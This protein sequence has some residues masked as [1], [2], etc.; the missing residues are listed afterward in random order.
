MDNRLQAFALQKKTSAA[1]RTLW[2]AVVTAALGAGG[3]I[4]TAV[5]SSQQSI[6]GTSINGQ[7]ATTA[8]GAVTAGVTLVGTALTLA[9]IGPAPADVLAAIDKADA[10]VIAD[11][12]AFAQNCPVVPVV[13]PGQTWTDGQYSAWYGQ[14]SGLGDSAAIQCTSDFKAVGLVVEPYN[15]PPDRQPL[16]LPPAALPPVGQPPPGGTGGT[17]NGAA[18]TPT[19]SAC[20]LSCGG[21][22]DG[23]R[24]Y[25]SAGHT[26]R[27]RLDSKR[28]DPPGV[29]NILS[30][31]RNQETMFVATSNMG[32][33]FSVDG[34]DQLHV[35]SKVAG[36]AG[37]CAW[38][39]SV[40][41]VGMTAT[42]SNPDASLSA[43]FSVSCQ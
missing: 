9:V 15:P 29:F 13:P 21:Q 27:F 22:G 5:S 8:L 43:R 41:A 24:L 14:C 38:S 36:T 33:A 37:G 19:A 17:A 20:P 11:W 10:R 23:T 25:M 6:N 1:S 40:D 30:M 31:A 35:C 28:A 4:A 18:P 32:D 39:C 12:G 34:S 26:Y 16:S 2:G 7:G 42:F 3:G